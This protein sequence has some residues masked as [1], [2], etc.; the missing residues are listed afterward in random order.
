M[1]PFHAKQVGLFGEINFKSLE[2][3]TP[4]A[5]SILDILSMQ[6]V[7][8]SRVKLDDEI[9]TKNCNQYTLNSWGN[10]YWITIQ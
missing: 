7:E 5:D 4:F 9:H 6:N 10:T 3:K 1:N 2:S 8:N